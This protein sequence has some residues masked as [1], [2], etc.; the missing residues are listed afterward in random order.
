MENS[1][2]GAG[3]VHNQYIKHIMKRTFL[4]SFYILALAICCGIQPVMAQKKKIISTAREQVKS[5]KNLDQAQK[6]MEALLA[7][8]TNKADKR[9]WET[10]F[11]AVR[12]QY[13][14]GNEKLYLKQAC[15]TASLFSLTRQ[16][17]VIAEGLDSLE[18][19]PNSKGKIDIEHRKAHAEYLEQIRPNLYNGGAWHLHK[20]NYAEA[21]LM[22]DQYIKSASQPLFRQYNYMVTDKKLSLAAYW[23]VYCGYKSKDA[24]M[25]L[26][27]S[28]E[29]LKDTAH[30]E[31]MLQYLAETY[32][33]E[34]DTGRYVNAIK[35]GFERA[36]RFPYFFPRLVEHYVND[37]QP[38]SAMAVV[39]HAL[40]MD[41]DNAMYLF[42]KSTL[43]LNGGKYEEC[44]AICEQIIAQTD[45]IADAYYNAGL[46]YYNMA[47][48]MDK[49]PQ[50]ARKKHK[51]I[52]EAY[53][54]AMPYL[55][56][57]RNLQPGQTQKW[58]LPLYTIYLNLNM[59]TEFEEIDKLLKET[60]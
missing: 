59:G 50:A 46:A 42:S 3:D 13:E 6:S 9:I 38:D 40:S 47:T 58:G 43:L 45:S 54:K 44:I 26:H 37:G 56:Q 33:L 30:Y 57:F 12:K 36:P 11:G 35:E 22:F 55:Q 60:K 48:E 25:T 19:I 2:R 4:Y 49:N 53:K 41:K 24:K 10:L 20:K 7:D 23:A 28:Y 17:F 16:L 51:Q 15:D 52:M 21:Y 39:D 27:H 34:K 31:Y 8:S 5:G 14:Q 1:P 18:M 29:A 32:K